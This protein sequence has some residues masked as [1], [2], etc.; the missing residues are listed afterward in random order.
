MLQLLLQY[1]IDVRNASSLS[2]VLCMQRNPP[3]GRCTRRTF[4]LGETYDTI[5]FAVKKMT[6]VSWAEDL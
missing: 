6:S 3:E 4:F 5:L 1:G 2:T